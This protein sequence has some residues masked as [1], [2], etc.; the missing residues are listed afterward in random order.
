[1]QNR[2]TE[3][4]EKKNNFCGI[5]RMNGNNVPSFLTKNFID[6]GIHARDPVSFD[7]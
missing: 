6:V 1:M 4:I 5:Q 2:R 3:E 7:M